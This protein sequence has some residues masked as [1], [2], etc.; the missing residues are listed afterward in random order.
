MS[1]CIKCPQY[2]KM[3]FK[4]KNLSKIAPSNP[5]KPCVI[6]LQPSLKYT[7]CTRCK[8]CRICHTCYTNLKTTNNTRKCPICNQECEKCK[9]GEAHKNCTWMSRKNFVLETIIDIKPVIPSTPVTINSEPTERPIERKCIKCP[10]ITY[11]E[12]KHALKIMS[13]TCSFL[14]LCF[15]I[16]LI[17]V[18][19]FHSGPVN[20]LSFEFGFICIGIGFLICVL[21]V[22]ICNAP[23]CCDY[24][25]IT[26]VKELY[27]S[28]DY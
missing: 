9:N 19:S 5:I 1:N 10:S 11:W 27:C 16:G 17:A 13:H 15:F 6:C 7:G 25:I 4:K 12:I 22:C 23:C 21:T 14:V 2:L 26:C 28:D 8:G 3:C 20:D 24:N 18:C